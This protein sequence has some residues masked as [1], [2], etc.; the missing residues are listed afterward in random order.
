[1]ASQFSHSVTAATN[2]F[3]AVL[4]DEFGKIEEFGY[5]SITKAADGVDFVA[6]FVPL[7]ELNTQAEITKIIDGEECHRYVGRVYLS[8]KNRLQI[9]GVTETLLSAKELAVQQNVAA[10]LTAHVIETIPPEL[11]RFGKRKLGAKERQELRT[12][13]GSTISISINEITFSIPID[14]PIDDKALIHIADPLRMA[15]VEIEVTKKLCFSSEKN[16]CY[17]KIHNLTAGSRKS[18]ID[19]LT[20]KILV[21]SNNL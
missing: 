20:R 2:N 21:F 11:N 9:A 1:M 18:L 19:Y 4:R 10:P 16:V 12:A 6:D 3:D 17:A 8:S 7:F 13:Q 5:A 15:D 14:F